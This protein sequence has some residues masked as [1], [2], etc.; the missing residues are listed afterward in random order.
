MS[1]RKPEL[2]GE[3]RESGDEGGTPKIWTQIP[4]EG[5]APTGD[6]ASEG[7]IT[8]L[9]LRIQGPGVEVAT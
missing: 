3:R 2:P 5:E 7:V 6:G 9:L 4:K 8:Q 1:Q